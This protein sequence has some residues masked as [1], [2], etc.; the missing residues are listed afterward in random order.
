MPFCPKCKY[1]YNAG[2]TVCPDCGEKLVDQ[3]TEPAMEEKPDQDW[4]PLARLTSQQLADM[5]KEALEVKDIPAV[6]TSNTGHFGIT[7][8]MGISSF[9]PIGGGYVIYVPRDFAVE[10]DK[11]AAL[12]LGEDWEKAKI[13][14]IK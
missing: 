3:L 4:I 13:V 2:T 7:G 10:A 1:E 14:D 12:I 8:Q 6:L 5:L 9:R 11:E